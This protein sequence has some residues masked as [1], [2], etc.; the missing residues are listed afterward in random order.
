MTVATASTVSVS[1]HDV[2][3]VDITSLTFEP[4]AL[5]RSSAKRLWP[6]SIDAPRNDSSV[7]KCSWL[8]WTIR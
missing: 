5:V 8:S 6:I 1:A 2:G 4:S 7:G 3:D